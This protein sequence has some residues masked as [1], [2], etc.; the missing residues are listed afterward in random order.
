[1]L[2]PDVT[3]FA[4]DCFDRTPELIALGEASMRAVLPELRT[5]LNIP[6]V[7]IAPL[8]NDFAVA[9]PPVSSSQPQ[10]SPAA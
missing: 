8:A 6:A 3:G 2:N 7:D 4:F 5:L 1:V 9:S 10:A